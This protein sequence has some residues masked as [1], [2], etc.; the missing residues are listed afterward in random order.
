VAA[1]DA[2]EALALL[3]QV[4]NST[5]YFALKAIIERLSKKNA[6]LALRFAE[7]A[8]IRARRLE[9]PSRTWSLAEIG[10]LV[11]HF[12]KEEAGRKLI[13]EAAS[14]AH[15]LGAQG[16]QALARGMVA[17]ALAPYDLKRA[18]HLLEPMTEGRDILRYAAMIFSAA[19][20]DDPSLYP[21]TRMQ[22]AYRLAATDAPAALRIVDSIKDR[23][24][25]KT[26]AEALAWV[27]VAVAPRDKMLAYTLIDRSLAIYVDEPN[28][29][30][31]WSNYGA[32]SVF[33]ARVA[34]QAREI[35]YPDMESVVARVLAVRQIDRYES[36]AR[37]TESQVAT[38]MVLALTDPATARQLLLPLEPRK[39]LIGSGYSSI[40]RSFWLQA[41]A[42]AD[43]THAVELFDRELAALKQDGTTDLYDN[44]VVGM[45][46]LL[47]TPPEERARYLLRHYGVFWF[48]GEE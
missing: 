48:P 28:E 22:I 30:R 15:K 43:L 44:G 19:M 45:I 25:G 18:Q 14:M 1:T 27:A 36:P 10:T 40:R 32:P 46:E 3:A 17:Q 5:A 16:H 34:G 13:D 26:K 8:T 12:G 2:D 33:A 29:L 42:L 11:R 31:S 47:T 20:K 24:D 7:E 38:A 35:G 39:N 23:G 21:R 6:P 37:A 41:W 4:D 9:Q